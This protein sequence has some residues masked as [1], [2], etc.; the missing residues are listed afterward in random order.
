[1][2][3]SKLPDTSLDADHAY[4]T[5][6]S[7]T[8]FTYQVSTSGTVATYTA[9]YRYEIAATLITSV[10]VDSDGNP[11]AD[12][13][14]I[15]SA[16]P[17]G[18]PAPAGQ[19]ELDGAWLGVFSDGIPTGISGDTG[20]VFTNWSGSSDST[21]TLTLTT[22]VNA[23]GITFTGPP[24]NFVMPSIRRAAG[25]NYVN[26]AAAEFLARFGFLRFMDGGRTNLNAFVKSWAN[27]P[28][29]YCGLGMPVAD[30]V[31]MCN[32]LQCG[33]WY[34]VPDYA[35]DDYILQVATYIKNNLDP[36][37]WCAF[38]FSNEVW[39]EGTFPHFYWSINR[40]ARRL[41]A[42]FHGFASGTFGAGGMHNV[43]TSVTK[44][45]VVGVTTVTVN[46]NRAPPFTTGTTAVFK[47]TSGSTTGY[48]TPNT[49]AVCTVT[50]N[51][52]SFVGGTSG[53]G[54]AT[55][56]QAA[57]IGNPTHALYA[58]DFLT[59]ARLMATRMHGLKTY[60]MG[61]IVKGV[62]GSLNDR[63]RI[64]LMGWEENFVPFGNQEDFS[65][66]WLEDE[67]GSLGDWC[68]GI[69]GAPYPVV[70]GADLAAIQTS[71]ASILT[72]METR[73]AHTKSVADSYGVHVCAYEWNV[74]YAGLSDQAL[75]DSTHTDP[76]GGAMHKSMID[77]L[78]PYYEL[79]CVFQSWG[80]FTK[81]PGDSHWHIS[82][83]LSDNKTYGAAN[84]EVM[85]ALDT[86][87]AAAPP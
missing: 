87:L 30:M 81:A 65:F 52:F 83:L 45:T 76:I 20:A 17:P 82:G 14:C 78:M 1:M 80:G 13:F 85:K 7:N 68:Y 12:V 64:M 50:G 56:T 4:I 70:A 33:M 40:A 18:S 51:S 41:S 38:E 6:L 84:D 48:N 66:P 16:I 54:T 28:R 26:A 59:D 60:E 67:Y 75:I 49:G 39:N 69:G 19:P 9:L 55:V 32:E 63:A 71:L 53:S 46:M 22:G 29:T 37:L 74:S 25:S 34:C 11:A 44:A 47:I 31:R 72:T 24:G 5:R 77:R 43:I 86:A 73:G 61:Q 23:I 35:D 79:F 36:S 3:E 57:I 42:Y 62:F 27:R 8:S 2:G 15:I 58:N 21:F 10:A